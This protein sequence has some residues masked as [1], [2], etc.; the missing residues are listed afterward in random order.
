MVATIIMCLMYNWKVFRFSIRW[1]LLL[2]MKNVNLMIQHTVVLYSIQLTASCMINTMGHNSRWNIK[3]KRFHFLSNM[4]SWNLII[5]VSFLFL[6]LWIVHTT[7]M[8]FGRFYGHITWNIFLIGRYWMLSRVQY[9]S[10]WWWQLHYQIQIVTRHCHFV[11][12][13]QYQSL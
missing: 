8:F 9:Y 12:P 2:C 4:K 7:M 13:F 11:H 5:K 3:C 1:K 6:L 10:D